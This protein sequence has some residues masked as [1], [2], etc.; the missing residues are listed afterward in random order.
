M[1][2][3]LLLLGLGVA[4][5]TSRKREPLIELK[6]LRLPGEF[7]IYDGYP[8]GIEPEGYRAIDLAVTDERGTYYDPRRFLQWSAL[9]AE[10]EVASPGWVAA[11]DE[12]TQTYFFGVVEGGTFTMYALGRQVG[13]ENC[14]REVLCARS[15]DSSYD[16]IRSDAGGVPE[17]WE[18]RLARTESGWRCSCTDRGVGCWVLGQSLPGNWPLA[19]T[20]PPVWGSWAGDVR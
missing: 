17:N 7:R 11:Q 3:R 20:T 6:L 4:A 2:G 8:H 1:L 9:A 16:E 15:T 18:A 12:L 13:P 5:A 10:H 14:C 19:K